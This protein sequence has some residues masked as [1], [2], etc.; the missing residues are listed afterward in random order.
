LNREGA[1]NAKM[2]TPHRQGPPVRMRD[3]VRVIN[4]LVQDSSLIARRTGGPGGLAFPF[5]AFAAFAPSR[6]KRK[7][8]ALSDRRRA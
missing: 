5:A 3:Q 8:E 1:K 2:G 4:L 7:P 6:F